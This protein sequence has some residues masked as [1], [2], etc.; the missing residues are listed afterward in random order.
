M[1]G[2][3]ARRR[4]VIGALLA[5][6]V[7]ATAAAQTPPAGGRSPGEEAERRAEAEKVLRIKALTL[8]IRV[9]LRRTD[10]PTAVRDIAAIG[11]RLVEAPKPGGW[12]G[13]FATEHRDTA[14]AF[15]DHVAQAV[16]KPQRW[17]T[18][19]PAETYR[20]LA[21]GTLS[22]G[23]SMYAEMMAAGR[24]PGLAIDEAYSALAWSQGRNP[25]AGDPALPTRLAERLLDRALPEPSV[26]S[27]ASATPAKP[28]APPSK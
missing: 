23:R 21:K 20:L 7:A 24:Y 13:V 1:T 9:T 16:A 6:A 18:D 4:A 14:A 26:A 28:G 15:F 27:P 17:P 12:A 25:P 22:G 2:R 3:H 11:K 19:Q 5:A 8:A 10:E